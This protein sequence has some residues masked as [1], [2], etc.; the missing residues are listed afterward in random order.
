MGATTQVRSNPSRPRTTSAARMDAGS[1]VSRHQGKLGQAFSSLNAVLQSRLRRSADGGKVISHATLADRSEFF[2]RMVRE[3]HAMDYRILDIRQLKPKHVEALMKRWEAAGLAA[4]TLQKRFSHL[5]VLCSWIGKAS[6]L[7]AGAAY[8]NDPE[9]FQRRYAAGYDHSWT[10]QG[11][12]PL[13]KIAEIAEDDP[14][15]ARVL[16]LQYAFGLRVQEASLLSPARDALEPD[17]LRVVAGTKGGRPRTVPIETEAQRALLQEAEAQARRT[18]HSMIP[19]HYDL[20]Q[21]L[22]RCYTVLA[23]HGVTR[24]NGLVTHGLRHQ[25]ANDRYEELT[26]EPS[27]VRGGAPVNARDDQAARLELTARL[28]H[29]RPSITRAYYGRESLVGVASPR[30][31]DEVKQHA[32]ALSVQKRLL[33]ARLKDRIGATTRRGLDAVSASTQALRA[34]L[35]NRMLADL[36]RLGVPLSTPDALSKSHVDALL[37]SWRQAS[38][39]ADSQ[40]Q[41]VQLLTQL[42]EWLDQPELAVQVR[43]AWKAETKAETPP[44]PWSEARIQERLQ[45]IRAVDERVAL[46]LE[47][48]RVFGMTHRQAGA[49]QPGTAYRD[50]VLEVLWEVPRDQVLRFPVAGERQQAVLEDARRLLP[51]PDT[52]VCPPELALDAWLRRVYDLMRTVG[53]IGIPGEPTL[54]ALQD[55]GAPA[56]QVL[57]RDAYL[58]A[59]A[60]LQR[61]RSTRR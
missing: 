47:L 61:P 43:N 57:S 5:R 34:R 4:S 2:S 55:R 33:A 58:L 12:D 9:R 60:G 3:L 23:R 54:R 27:P 37:R 15:V 11:V 53:G 32:R 1:D 51:D 8:L 41:R 35:L 7:H 38:L 45:A 40:R 59:R 46:H 6:M 10:A 24:K 30:S 36:L 29:A 19:P 18:G 28:G 50:G 52:T 39:T 56:P 21:W 26:G 13:D 44:C 14:D 17:T 16:R 42:C 49:L 31:A 25:Y 22:T 20:K 48:V